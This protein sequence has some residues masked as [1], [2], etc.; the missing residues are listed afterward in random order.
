MRRNPKR[1]A[2]DVVRPPRDTVNTTALYARF[3]SPVPLFAGRS[4]VNPHLLLPAD[5]G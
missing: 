1:P 4:T 5:T 2:H 3:H